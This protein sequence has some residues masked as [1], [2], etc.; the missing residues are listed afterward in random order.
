VVLQGLCEPHLHLDGP[1]GVDVEVGF[2]PEPLGREMQ[3]LSHVVG[4]GNTTRLRFA[5]EGN[6]LVSRG[7]S[8]Q[9][10]GEE[11]RLDS[12]PL[13]DDLLKLV[14]EVTPVMLALQL[15][16]PEK[17]DRDTLKSFWA[18]KPGTGPLRTRQVAMLW[19][20]RGDGE[21]PT[22]VALLWGQPEEAQALQQIFSGPNKM[23]SAT[24]CGHFVLASTQEVLERLRK[25]CEGKWPSM[26]N[27]AAPV[28]QGLRAPGSVSFGINTGRLLGTLMADGYGSQLPPVD[29]KKPQ[30]RTMPPEIEAARRDLETLPYIGLRG[31]VDGNKLVPGGFGS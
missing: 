7:I 12:A 21:L 30:P 9:V 4:L 1:E 23:E 19:T 22:E 18:G 26:L 8:A 14:P 11:A 10:G 29:P 15:R 24:L 28:L 16:L 3:L 20:P 27:A 31:T 13:S 5:V 17:L 6:R 2:A 25:S